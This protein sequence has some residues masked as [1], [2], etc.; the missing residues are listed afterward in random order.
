MP[1][2]T[3]PKNQLIQHLRELGQHAGARRENGLAVLEGVRLIEEALA[4]GVQVRQF[5]YTAELAQR[6]R[7]AELVQRLEAGGAEAYLTSQAALERAADTQS[8]QG[9]VAAFALPRWSTADLGPG[10]VLVCDGIAD[11]GNLGT[12][13]RSAEALGSGGLCLV[14]GADPWAPKVLRSA[15][16]ALFRLPVV[17]AD[18]PDDLIRSL[19]A[20]GR[21]VL[22]AAAADGPPLWQA[23]LTGSLAL[24][25]GSEARG[26]SA[27]A[28]AG[29]HGT[30]HIPM[31]GEAESLNAAMAA[32]LLLYEALRQ[33]RQSGS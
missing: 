18:A 2:I 21:R 16:G 8:P 12:I 33:R 24:V 7:G 26:A 20:A 4:A 1:E 3:S 19:A 25:V 14:G 28:R 6:E 9:I 30:V 15:M 23:E 32:S 5:L 10:P 11:P 27:A 13:A 17:Q 22:V 29:A 31:P